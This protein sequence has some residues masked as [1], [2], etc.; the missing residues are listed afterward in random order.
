MNWKYIQQ[1]VIRNEA[2]D[3]G[4][5]GGGG[6]GEGQSSIPLLDENMNFS[7]GYQERIGEYAKDATF[8]DLPS[9]F[10]SQ[11]EGTATIRALNEEKATLATQLKEAQQGTQSVDIPKSIEEY[12]SA[13]SAPSGEDLPEGV[14]VPQDLLDKAAQYGLDEGIA[15]EVVNKFI[16]FQVS[17]AG[18]EFQTE[19][20]AFQNRVQQSTVAIKEA[21][22]EQNYD[23][24]VAN[25]KAASEVLGLNLSADDLA[26]SPNMVLALANIKNQ[27]S[28]GAL[29]G[30]SL[31]DPGA[32]IL[33]GSKLQQAEDIVS[34]PSN[35]LHD[36]FM[37]SS[38]PKHQIAHDTHSRLISESSSV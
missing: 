20:A 9:V 38:H 35:P 15:P 27:I 13:L 19:A 3:G 10:K 14:Q 8:K 22:G 32:N 7:E 28:E 21:V 12:S 24:T 5:G 16:A 4:D 18:E 36:P 29:K 37:D 33:A 11:Q 6:G 34:N 17:Q 2:G 25:A 30:A 1:G 31:S 26:S 23:T